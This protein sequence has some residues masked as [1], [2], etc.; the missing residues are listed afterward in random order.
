MN[1]IFDDNDNE[2]ELSGTG[3]PYFDFHFENYEENQ[4]DETGEN[5]DALEGTI[6]RHQFYS[7]TLANKTRACSPPDSC[8][9]GR[10]ARWAMSVSVIAFET[11]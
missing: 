10:S 11:A 4:E 5:G 6:Y 8:N 2:E 9:T 1:N 7:K 3:S